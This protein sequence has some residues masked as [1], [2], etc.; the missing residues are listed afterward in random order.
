MENKDKPA[1]Y[2]AKKAYKELLSLLKKYKDVYTYEI[3]NIESKVEAYLFWLEIKETYGLNLN[4]E[5][6]RSKDYHT[7]GDHRFI[8]MW[9]EKFRRTISWSVDDRQ[10]EDEML[11]DISFP[12]GAYIFGQ[13]YPQSI[14]QR[15]WL[16]LKSFNPDYIDEVNHC[17]YW[18]IENAKDVFNSFD[19]VLKKYHKINE[20]DS[21]TRKIETLK[22]QLQELEN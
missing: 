17:L 20:E 10:P 1:T 21:K 14:F 18:K 19:S 16:E 2:K 12:T 5:E 13:D 7:F 22:K 9:G 6:P 15:F 8:G 11:L 3:R 4:P